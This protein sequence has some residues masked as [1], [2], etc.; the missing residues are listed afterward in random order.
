MFTRLAGEYDY[1]ARDR[2]R[3][4][5]TRSRPGSAAVEDQQQRHH[6]NDTAMSAA[7]SSNGL[8]PD[9][10]GGGISDDVRR[11]SGS[12]L[13][14][15]DRE[16]DSSS[17]S[18][19]SSEDSDYGPPPPPGTNTRHNRHGKSRGPVIPTLEDL[20]LRREEAESEQ[21][22]QLTALRQARK[23]DRQLQKERL[24]DVL[25]PKAD[26]GT[27]ERRL[28]KRAALNEK[29]RAF[30]DPSPGGQE[31]NESELIGGG[32]DSVAEYKKMMAKEEQRKTERQL[33]RE[34][35]A[36]ARAAEREEKIAKAREREERTMVGLRELARR[37]F[38]E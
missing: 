24:D 37:R 26:A 3:G 25:P 2:D 9:G 20:A 28:E 31:V 6:N 32:E 18:S 17:P 27:R 29:M 38:G 14:N 15:H 34:E 10:D 13:S 12:I 23:A 22:S 8:E 5:E 30:R 19:P 35:A 11:D 16:D 4:I 33:R 36:R 7:S 1:A 21:Q